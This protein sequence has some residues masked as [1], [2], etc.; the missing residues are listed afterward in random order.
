MNIIFGIVINNLGYLIISNLIVAPIKNIMRCII[1]TANSL[2]FLISFFYLI[3][4]CFYSEVL[5]PMYHMYYSKFEPF[6]ITS[7]N[8]TIHKATIVNNDTAF[9]TLTKF[10]IFVYF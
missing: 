5:Y 7:T 3:N 6:F 8:T 4:L 9:N 10:F 2:I 1:P